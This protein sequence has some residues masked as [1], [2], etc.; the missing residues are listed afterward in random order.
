M[1]RDKEKRKICE[2]EG[3]TLIEIPYWWDKKIPSLATTIQQQRPDLIQNQKEEGEVIP[4]Q[5][6]GGFP[7]GL[8]FSIHQINLYRLIGYKQELMHGIEWDGIQDLTGW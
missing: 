4:L 2:K 7:I 3:I 5:P 8:Y 1:K 6:P